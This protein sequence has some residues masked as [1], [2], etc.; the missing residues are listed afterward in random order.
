M[1]NVRH[2]SGE[3]T[4][5]YCI[6]VPTENPDYAAV[7]FEK[8]AKLVAKS[9]PEGRYVSALNGPYFVDYDSHYVI[10]VHFSV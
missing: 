9:H 4:E 2:A 7:L 5:V 3:N 10:D 8:L 1:E 6:E